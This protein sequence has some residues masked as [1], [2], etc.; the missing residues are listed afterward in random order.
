ML[1]NWCPKSLLYLGDYLSR[2][3]KFSDVILLNMFY[4]SLFYTSSLSS[5]PISHRF[6]L[7]IVSQRYCKFHL[8]VLIILSLLLPECSNSS[9]LSS[10][11]S[12]CWSSLLARFS[13]EFFE[14]LSFSFLEFW[15]DFF[16]RF[17]YLYWIPLSYPTLSSLF[18][19]AVYLYSLWI[20]S[21]V[22][23]YPL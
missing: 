7:L 8:Y 19:S 4:I 21:G 11:L 20:H 15:F 2:L 22:Y 13:A 12:F 5:M 16:S 14:L 17:L 23:T 1:C 6:G 18:H 3:E 10:S 9:T